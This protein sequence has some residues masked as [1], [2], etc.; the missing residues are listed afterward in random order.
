MPRVEQ[1][2][3][4]ETGQISLFALEFFGESVP[5]SERVRALHGPVKAEKKLEDMCKESRS[6]SRSS[7]PKTSKVAGEKTKEF[8]A[9][10]I[11]KIWGCLK[12]HGNKTY[13]EIALLTGLEPVAVAR[14]RK[15]M[16][17][18]HLIEVLEETRIGCALWRAK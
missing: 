13:K 10:H 14:R 3:L 9:R 5:I 18:N 2:K 6:L 12:D 1:I 7:D 11:A 16:E 17:E 8:R 15:E 4:N